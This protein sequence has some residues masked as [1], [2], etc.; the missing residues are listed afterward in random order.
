MRMLFAKIMPRMLAFLTCILIVSSSS[1][2]SAS[3]DKCESQCGPAPCCMILWVPWCGCW[4]DNNTEVTS[5]SSSERPLDSAVNDTD[6]NA[7]LAC[8]PQEAASTF[9]NNATLGAYGP[10][11]DAAMSAL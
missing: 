8:F 9:A 6:P 1:P 2:A 3:V 4:F 7:L 11:N 5:D 10:L